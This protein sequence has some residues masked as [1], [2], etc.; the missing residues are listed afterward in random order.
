MGLREEKKEELR[1]RI[2]EVA[3]GLFRERGYDATRIQDVIARV[4]ISEATFFNYYPTKEAVL[5]AYALERLERY[6]DLLRDAIGADRSVPDRIRDLLRVMALSFSEDREFMAVVAQR[7]QLFFGAQGAILQHEL[8]TF[9]LLKRLFREGQ[10]RGEI[11]D[12][13]DPLQ[14]AEIL[15]GTYSTTLFNW[16]VG[17]WGD[18]GDLEERLMRAADVFLDG[19]RPPESQEQER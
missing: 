19:C 18:R 13:V 10:V 11:R 16:V 3:V 8:L 7:S 1:R 17:W 5:D 12:D 2:L 15:T 6:A 4:R 14:L 9:D